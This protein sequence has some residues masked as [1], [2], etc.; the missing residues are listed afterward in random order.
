MT[1]LNNEITIS[2]P[3]GSIESDNFV[4]D[5]DQMHE[6]AVIVHRNRRLA[7][8]HTRRGERKVL[9]ILVQD[10]YGNAPHQSEDRM[11]RDLFGIG[12]P[13]GSN[14]LVRVCGFISSVKRFCC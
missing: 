2:T 13:L 8:K 1:C 7:N 11:S 6:D 14:N 10:R 5:L 3:P 12:E 4:I 9:V